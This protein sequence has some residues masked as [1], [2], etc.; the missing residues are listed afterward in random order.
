MRKMSGVP[1]YATS[2]EPFESLYS[3]VRRS[4]HSGT[5]NI[6]KQVLENGYLRIKYYHIYVD[7][8]RRFLIV[9]S[10]QEHQLPWKREGPDNQEG[11]AQHEGPR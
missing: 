5:R 4:Y 3:V 6:P 11:H 7:L 1:L 2:A 9:I 10:L 8:N